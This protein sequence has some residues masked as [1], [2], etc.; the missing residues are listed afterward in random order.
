MFGRLP[1]TK[2]SDGPMT[3]AVKQSQPCQYG[4]TIHLSAQAVQPVRQAVVAEIQRETTIAG[5][6]KGKAPTELVEQH[7]P[8]VIREETVRRLTRQAVER[9]TNERKLKPVGP[10]E[11]T[12]V[13]F[14]EAKGLQLEAQVEVEPEFPL[15][16]Y[17][18]IPLTRPPVTVTEQDVQQALARLQE[19]MAQLV[20]TG[21]G[22]AKAKQLPSLNDEFAKDV[23]CETLD[24]LKALAAIV[25]SRM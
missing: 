4:F 24:Q 2:T 7:H 11:V 23:G 3:V 15:G 6:R 9:V 13:E 21:V 22:Q 14:D 10:F 19:S 5:F 18:R 12:R 25:L 16:E 20:P 8:T 17:R 1:K